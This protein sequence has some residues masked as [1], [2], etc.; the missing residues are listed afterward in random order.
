MSKPEVAGR[1][2][3]LSTG[4]SYGVH[5]TVRRT[6]KLKLSY[7]LR[8]SLSTVLVLYECTERTTVQYERSHRGLRA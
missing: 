5:Y 2:Y 1:K 4:V 8:C 6:R 3:S 7:K